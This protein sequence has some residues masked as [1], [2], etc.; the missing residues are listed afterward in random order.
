MLSAVWFF[1]LS[2]LLNLFCRCHSA[3]KQTLPASMPSWVKSE[4][5]SLL[6]HCYFDHW[7]LPSGVSLTASITRFSGKH[8]LASLYSPHWTSLRPKDTIYPTSNVNTSQESHFPMQINLWSHTKTDFC[9]KHFPVWIN[10]CSRTKTDFCCNL[11][12]QLQTPISPSENSYI[13]LSYK[14]FI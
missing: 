4:F 3:E 7:P 9:C 10:L 5:A 11:E 13:G 2:L 6:W 8:I 14:L 12:T 1:V